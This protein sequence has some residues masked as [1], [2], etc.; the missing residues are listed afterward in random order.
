[1]V[2][3]TGADLSEA[4]EGAGVDELLLEGRT[5]GFGNGA[6]MADG[7]SSVEVIR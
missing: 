6:A 5:E 1:V 2:K 7:C 4:D 3:D